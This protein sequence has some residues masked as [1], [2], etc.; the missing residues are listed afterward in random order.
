[1]Q[2]QFVCGVRCEEFRN[3]V[4][5]GEILRDF[6]LNVVF[7]PP[8][9]QANIGPNNNVCT[10]G[11]IFFNNTSDPANSYFWDFGDLSV[12]TDT[13]SQQFPSYT[14]PGLGP[15]SVTLIINYGTPCADTAYQII[16]ISSVTAFTATPAGDS[17]CVGQTLT[18]QDSSV[19]TGNAV[20][21]GY[22]WDFGDMTS[23]TGAVVSHAWA[24]SGTYTVTHIAQNSLG[25]DDTVQTVVYIVAPPIALAG[26]D[27]FACTNNSTVGL[28]GTILNA[29]GGM[30][31]GLGTFNPNNTTTNAVTEK[32]EAA[33]QKQ[34][35][36]SRYWKDSK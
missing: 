29:T 22:N 2:G 13:S 18:F 36:K 14:Y 7:C 26:N 31:N 24:A 20:L 30:W 17:A 15:Y 34:I 25:C 12:T 27:T 16:D 35:K 21:S 5:I 28:G 33:A 19:V 3:G 1:M 4:K 6:Q 23:D 10:G 9:A 32:A 11:T 8:L